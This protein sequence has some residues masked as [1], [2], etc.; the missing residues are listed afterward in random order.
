[1][2]NGKRV[3]KLSYFFL[4]KWYTTTD[5]PEMFEET[6]FEVYQLNIEQQF[7]P[8]LNFYIFVYK[9]QS[10]E[11]LGDEDSAENKQEIDELWGELS[12]SRLSYA[13]YY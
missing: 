2:L 1:M 12:E 7:S 6:L 4:L 3:T 11:L 9:I 5:N 8:F 13:A 10:F